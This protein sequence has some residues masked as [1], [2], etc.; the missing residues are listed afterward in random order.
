[1]KEHKDSD[2]SGDDDDKDGAY[3]GTGLSKED[4]MKLLEIA[5][6]NALNVHGGLNKNESIA[7]RHGGLTIEKL[8]EKCQRVAD[9]KEDPVTEDIPD[10]MLNHPFEMVEKAPEQLT[11]RYE[12]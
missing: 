2:D 9:G 5:K 3:S 12:S 6:K 7:M 11:F 8:T 10:D 4:K 1:M